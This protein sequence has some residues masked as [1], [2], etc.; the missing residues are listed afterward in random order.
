MKKPAE[1]R[2]FRWVLHPCSGMA[3]RSE[4]HFQTYE[5]AATENVVVAGEGRVAVR[6]GVWRPEIRTD[7]RWFL[8]EQVVHTEADVVLVPGVA[9]VQREDVVGAGALNRGCRVQGFGR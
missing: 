7:D 4:S 9:A 6:V 1:C 8:V 2:L 3:C 5:P